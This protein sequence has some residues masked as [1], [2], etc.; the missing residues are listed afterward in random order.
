M[1]KRSSLLPAFINKGR[2]KFYNTGLWVT[3]G[4]NK[5]I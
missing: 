5:P 3:V 4:G 2:K 1:D